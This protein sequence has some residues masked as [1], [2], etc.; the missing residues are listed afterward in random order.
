MPDTGL[1]VKNTAD[2]QGKT[3]KRLKAPQGADSR[4]CLCTY[5]LYTTFPAAVRVFSIGKKRPVYVAGGNLTPPVLGGRQGPFL[6]RTGGIYEM[7]T[8]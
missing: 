3:E 2:E 6:G 7:A 4:F 5:L 1:K 8:P